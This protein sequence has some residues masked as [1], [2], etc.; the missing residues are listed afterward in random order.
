M[1]LSKYIIVLKDNEENE[2]NTTDKN[3]SRPAK[4]IYIYILCC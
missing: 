4:D 1:I 2:F 3:I